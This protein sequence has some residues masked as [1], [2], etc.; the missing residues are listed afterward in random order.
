MGQK[1]IS[2]GPCWT[3]KNYRGQY[4]YPYVIT[5]IINKFVNKKNHAWMKCDK[6]NIASQKGI[7]RAGFKIVGY[8]EKTK[9]LG[10]KFLNQFNITKK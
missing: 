10:L 3:H 1:D 7:L 6:N 2:I 4:L 8:G 5:E 9:I